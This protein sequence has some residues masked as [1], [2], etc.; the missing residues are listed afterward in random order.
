MHFL[1]QRVIM[2]TGKG[3]VGRTTVSVALARAAARVGRK[4]LLMGAYEDGVQSAVGE[5][6]GCGRL[7]DIPEKVENNYRSRICGLEQV[8]RVSF[9]QFCQAPP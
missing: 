5:V 3:G 1:N 6:L 7:S 9:E 2:V 4:T 8:T